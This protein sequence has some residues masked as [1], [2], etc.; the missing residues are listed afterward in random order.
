M[1]FDQWHIPTYVFIAWFPFY[2]IEIQTTD[3]DATHMLTISLYN[4]IG[5]ATFSNA[6]KMV[7]IQFTQSQQYNLSAHQTKNNAKYLH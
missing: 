5:V 1:F 2:G 3:V 4:I 6:N 7:P